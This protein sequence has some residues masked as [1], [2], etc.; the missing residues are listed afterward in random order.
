MD[1][2]PTPLIIPDD[3]DFSDLALLLDPDTGDLSF[4]WAPIERIC[5]ASGLEIAIFEDES[6]DNLSEL[7]IEWYAVHLASGGEPDPVQ[8]SLAGGDDSDD[9]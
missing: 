3:L 2:H 5:E 7:I 6:T 8:E 9:V 4:D 1:N